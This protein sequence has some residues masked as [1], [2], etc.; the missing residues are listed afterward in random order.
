MHTTLGLHGSLQNIHR[1]EKE[2][3]SNG[4]PYLTPDSLKKK[5][6]QHR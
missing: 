5:E 3:W 4:S 1:W 2:L 6:A